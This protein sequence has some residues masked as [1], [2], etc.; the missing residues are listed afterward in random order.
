METIHYVDD[1][2]VFVSLLPYY[3]CYFVE[4]ILITVAQYVI[5]FKISVEVN[6]K[7]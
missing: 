5:N 2:F 7:I 1:S 3:L 6:E 4:H